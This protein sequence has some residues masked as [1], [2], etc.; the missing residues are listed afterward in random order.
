MKIKAFILN[1][2][3]LSDVKNNVRK[4]KYKGFLK[5]RVGGKDGDRFFSLK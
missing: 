1:L 3:Q 2:A 5:S 4:K